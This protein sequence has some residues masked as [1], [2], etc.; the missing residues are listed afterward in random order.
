ML[1]VTKLM[2]QLFSFVY[3]GFNFTSTL[4]TFLSFQLRQNNVASFFVVG[5]LA[6]SR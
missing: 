1:T 4:H 6:N 3:A 2:F 5:S